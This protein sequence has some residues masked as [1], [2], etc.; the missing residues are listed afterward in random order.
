[1]L[2]AGN[3]IFDETLLEIDGVSANFLERKFAGNF[4]LTSSEAELAMQ[5]YKI[6]SNEEEE[7][8]EHQS[9]SG[10]HHQLA[11]GDL[12]EEQIDEDAGG[13]ANS[14]NY[15]QKELEKKSK[16]RFHDWFNGY[17]VPNMTVR[18]LN[19]DS[20]FRQLVDFDANKA[21]EIKLGEIFK[22][23]KHT[24]ITLKIAPMAICST[25]PRGGG[26]F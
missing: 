20:V 9:E 5:Q 19:P 23:V 6:S 24:V 17:F 1:M 8:G 25:P 11:A 18:L 10:E 12:E 22:M 14:G 21:R 2:A 3:L 16:K 13:G 26:L 7:G 4:G 15:K